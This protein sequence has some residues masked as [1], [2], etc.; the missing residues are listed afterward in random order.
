[1]KTIAIAITICL[2][3][4]HVSVLKGLFKL[5]RSRQLSNFNVERFKT[6]KLKILRAFKNIKFELESMRSVYLN[7]QGGR[8]KT[9]TLDLNSQYIFRHACLECGQWICNWRKFHQK[10]IKLQACK[11]VPLS[12]YFKSVCQGNQIIF[13]DKMFQ[14]LIC[15]WTLWVK[16]FDASDKSKFETF[17]R[18]K[19]QFTFV[20]WREKEA[21]Q[22]ERCSIFRPGCLIKSMKILAICDRRKSRTRLTY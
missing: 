7:V 11:A 9:H 22:T 3:L 2:K 13:L 5:E 20:N 14:L 8:K 16:W 15:H 4:D 21:C 6:W 1:M 19:F 12:Q 17:L 18:W 10:I